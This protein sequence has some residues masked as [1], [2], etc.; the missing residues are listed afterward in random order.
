MMAKFKAK[1]IVVGES[2]KGDIR[3]YSSRAGGLV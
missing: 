1:L 2:I 3:R